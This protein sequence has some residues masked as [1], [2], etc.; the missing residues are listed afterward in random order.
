MDGS[1][2]AR[3]TAAVRT[4]AREAGFQ[5]VGIA[6]AVRPPGA[7]HLHEWLQQGYA[8]RME[9][10]ER[11]LD[12][13]EDPDRVLSGV[14]TVVMVGLN[15]AS[16]EPVEPPSGCGRISRYAW[17]DR[18]YHDVI[19]ENLKPVA[20]AIHEVMSAAR[21]RIVVDTAP[22]LERDFAQL[23]GLGWFGKNT[24]LINKWQGS[25]FFLGA[26][27]TDVELEYDA[28]HHTAHCGTCTACM[29]A[30]PTDAF[31]EP[32]VL[33]ARRCI[34]YLNIELRDEPV[35]PELRPGMQ[36]WL[37]GCD[38]CQDVC[39]W[40]RKAPADNRRFAAVPGRNPVD[41]V[42]LLM[43]TEE[44]FRVRFRDTPLYRTGRDTIARNAAIVLGNT[45]ST[46]HVDPL[47]TARRTASPMVAEAIDDAITRIR[48]RAASD[49]QS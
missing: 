15:Y 29:D 44:Q 37:F 31:P 33:D 38:I 1:Q 11:R 13:Y 18:D 17:N 27:L 35:P 4:A 46:Q 22:L 12:A 25:W 24:L 16:D 36:D 21:T 49:A 3:C 2:I 26:L 5:L 23:A 34:S 19:R 32:W 30:C 39:P 20:A 41:C 43:M 6:P 10:I 8:G 14:R 9:W 28:P 40:N 7:D 45:G 42:A 48:A 47:L